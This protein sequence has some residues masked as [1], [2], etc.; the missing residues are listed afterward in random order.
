MDRKLR[1]QAMRSQ[2][3]IMPVAMPAG[4]ADSHRI[5]VA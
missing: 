3:A 2:V 1:V 4:R 5:H